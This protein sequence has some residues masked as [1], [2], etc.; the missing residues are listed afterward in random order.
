MKI[1]EVARLDLDLYNRIQSEI[2]LPVGEKSAKIQGCHSFK[3]YKYNQVVL[4]MLDH[5]PSSSILHADQRSSFHI[6]KGR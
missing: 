5:I 1:D 6:G 3:V 4:L 2:L